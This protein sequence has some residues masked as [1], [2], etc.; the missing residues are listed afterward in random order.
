MSLYAL[1]V[2]IDA[3]LPP[4]N[5][6]YGCRND[7]AALEQYLKGRVEGGLELR[8]LYDAEATRDRVVAAFRE[9]LGQAGAGDTALFAYAGHGSEEPAPLEVSALEPTGRIQTLV[10]HDCGRRLEGTLI[11]ALADKELALL[12]SEVTSRGPH[13]AVVLD[14]CHSGGGTRDPFARSR[15]WTPE[16]QAAPEEL[17]EL[18][19]EMG[20]ARASKEFLPGA[21]DAWVAPEPPHVA[22]AACRSFE[23]AKEHRVGD[24]TRGAFSV[25][26]VESLDALGARTTYR[27]LLNTVRSRVERAAVE[28]SPELYPVDTG[29]LGDSLFLDGT[30]TPIAATFTVSRG[31]KGWEVDAGLVHGLRPAV[32]EEAFLLACLDAEGKVAGAVRVT[33]VDIGRSAVEPI[34]WEPADVAYPAV[35]ADVPLPP[36]EVQL[37]AE[38]EVE[39]V[40]DSAVAEVATAVGTALESAGPGGSPSPYV[41]IV[42]PGSGTPGALRLR[43][44]VPVVGVGRITRADGESSV[45][46]DTAVCGPGVA[47]DGGARLLVSRLEHVARWEMVRALGGH[48]SPL[49]DAVVLD[50]F[51]AREGETT[52]PPDRPPIAADGGYRFGYRRAADES[53][54]EPQVFVEMRNT[55]EEALWVAVLDLTDRYRCHALFPTALVAAGH[56]V[57]VWNGHPIPITVPDDAVRPGSVARDWLKVI[58][59]DV[60]FD[61]MAFDLP[62]LDHPIEPSPARRS[63]VLG[64]LERLAARAITRDIGA[65]GPPP[66]AARWAASTV[67]LEVSVPAGLQAASSR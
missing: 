56:S 11:R 25:A 23:K 57:A 51:E 49:S 60:N 44:R 58:V 2:G 66:V 42:D 28:Q 21:L 17:R 4:I 16:E 13:V 48:P 27:S 8:T 14:C 10:L 67:A 5:A 54:T 50:L 15:G 35:V 22:L 46:P 29:G 33:A 19:R 55:T 7:M 3:Y 18:V 64:T 65:G 36:A 63:A 43:V 20:A 47:G 26:L 37:D 12:L 34:D 1:L 59:S 61:A 53:W 45:G 62:P 32:G 52:R 31:A 6:L 24:A 39:G 9:H 30:V 41:R 38:S 40:E